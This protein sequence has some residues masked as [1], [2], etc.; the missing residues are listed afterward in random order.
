L[1][2]LQQEMQSGTKQ[3]ESS[4]MA[5]LNDAADI[6]LPVSDAS[7]PMSSTLIDGGVKPPKKRTVKPKQPK[8]APDASILNTPNTSISKKSRVK[9]QPVA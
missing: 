1:Q 6:A 5:H 3:V 7:Q 9:K 2:K 8:S 4:I